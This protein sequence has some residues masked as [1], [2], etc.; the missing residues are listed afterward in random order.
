MDSRP[1]FRAIDCL[2]LTIQF[3]QSAFVHPSSITSGECFV[4]RFLCTIVICGLAGFSPLSAK[5][6]MKALIIDGQNNHKVWPKTT[7]LMKTSLEETKLF[8]V[9]VMTSV[10]KG[11][12]PDFKPD[13]S[14]Y[15]VVINN[16]GHGA[17]ALPKETNRLSKNT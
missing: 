4:F 2:F 6:P 11:M 12:S 14:Q 1:V 10:P 7:K 15:D 9:D 8:T 16:F 13:F 17:A 3:I 5:E